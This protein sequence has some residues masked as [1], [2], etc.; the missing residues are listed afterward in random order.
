MAQLGDTLRVAIDLR[1][2]LSTPSLAG[3]TLSIV[4]RRG[5]GSALVRNATES[6]TV[7]GRVEVQL[8]TGDVQSA[9]IWSAQALV[10]YGDGTE[11]RSRPRSFEVLHNLPTS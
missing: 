6:L 8:Q 5:D 1:D 7:P 2:D 3:A 9:G 4:F 10:V 11:F